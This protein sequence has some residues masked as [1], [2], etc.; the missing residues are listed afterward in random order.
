LDLAK[1]AQQAQID[2]SSALRWFEILED[3]LIV[4]RVESFAKSARKR[5]V[6]HPRFFLFDNGILNALLRNFESSPDRIGMLFENLF[7]SQI[8]ASAAAVDK[9]I[10]VSNFRTAQG[11][12]VD[13]VVEIG[14]EVYAIECKASVNEPRFSTVGFDALEKVCRRPFRK[15]VAYLGSTALQRNDVTILPWQQALKEIEQTAV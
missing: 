5:L 12:E 8:F 4:H 11:A 6:Q 7:C 15:I 1:L 9:E 14:N 3:T 10:T 2:R 13:F